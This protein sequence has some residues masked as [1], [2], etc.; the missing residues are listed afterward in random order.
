VKGYK[1][2]LVESGAKG[3]LEKRFFLG[4]GRLKGGKTLKTARY[5][6]RV[7]VTLSEESKELKRKHFKKRQGRGERGQGMK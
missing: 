4:K 3:K 5:Q 6:K 2:F 1:F 7:S